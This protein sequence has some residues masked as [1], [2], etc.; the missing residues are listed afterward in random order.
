MCVSAVLQP[1]SV[2][3]IGAGTM[4]QGIAI[5]LLKKTD[6]ELILLDVQP[7]ALARA[8]E[9]F[10]AMRAA[11]VKESR[12]RS[13][14][15]KRAEARITFT[16]SYDSLARADIVWEVATERGEIKAKI[17]EAIEGHIDRD[18]IAAI[19]SNT[20]S[21]TTGELAFLFK[22]EALREKFLTVHGYFPFHENRLINV[23]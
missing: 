14:D 5:D 20:S 13:E 6:Y 7:E 16:Q 15:A 19:F 11:D 4:G 3:F 12:S 21:H 18:R 9:R 8:K 1:A 2:A 22:S 23:I 17:F 10:D